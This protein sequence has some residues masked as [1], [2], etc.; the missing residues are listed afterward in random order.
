MLAN[1]GTAVR[2]KQATGSG[3]PLVLFCIPHAGG[4]ASAFRGWQAALAPLVRVQVLQL[5]GREGRF[6]EPPLL[7]L[8]DVLRDLQHAAAPNLSEPFALF[9]HS[10]G[11]L[12]AF[13]LTHLFRDAGREPAHLF[14]SA[15][16]APQF[17]QLETPCCSLS[18]PQFVA[19]VMQRYGGIP[20]AVLA[21]AGFMA[22]I[23]PA[24]R[25]DFNIVERYRLPARP[26][27]ACPISA[28][29]GRQDTATPQS[30][31]AAWV[32]R[33]AGPFHLE[34]FDDGHFYLQS[35]RSVLV[36]RILAA[37]SS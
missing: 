37:L 34:M 11:A 28:F 36:S 15:C 26:P 33:T 5:P 7:D 6:R 29:G 10:M 24:L 2:A 25:A 17:P 32:H 22:A 27:L 20:E 13:E 18:D 21:D 12:L 9:G 35:K 31:V 8:Q 3:R 14:V 23:L 1:I 19:E 30:A 16:R 4:G